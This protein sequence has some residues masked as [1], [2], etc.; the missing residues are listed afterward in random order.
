MNRLFVEEDTAD[1]RFLIESRL[2][3][4]C[5]SHLNG[6]WWTASQLLNRNFSSF[7]IVIGL[8]MLLPVIC[9]SLLQSSSLWAW[10]RLE[11]FLQG[12][13]WLLVGFNVRSLFAVCMGSSFVSL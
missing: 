12:H 9:A 13:I 6:I 7:D 4:R 2:C 5:G 3:E 11:L 1:S 8:Q 10:Y